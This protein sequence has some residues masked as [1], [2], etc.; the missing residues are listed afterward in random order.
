M[1]VG[2]LGFTAFLCGHIAVYALVLKYLPPAGAAGAVAGGDLALAVIVLLI[3]MGKSGPSS[4][5]R[6]AQ[7][8]SLAA[9]NQIRASLNWTRMG[10]IAW[11]FVRDRRR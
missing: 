2:L 8:V 4:G 1:V 11:Q 7:E 10:L 5:E 3:A 9:Q 6:E